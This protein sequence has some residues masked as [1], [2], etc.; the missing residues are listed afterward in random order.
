MSKSHGLKKSHCQCKRVIENK[1]SNRDY[2]LTYLPGECAHKNEE[3]EEEETKIFSY[4][5]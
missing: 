1:H 4:L 5:R 2:C 3:A